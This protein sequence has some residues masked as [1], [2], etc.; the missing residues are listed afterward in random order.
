MEYDTRLFAADRLPSGHPPP[1]DESPDQQHARMAHD[2]L[3]AMGMPRV[4]LH[5]VGRF[6]IARNLVGLLVQDRQELVTSW[7]PGEPLA[8]PVLGA[9]AL[10]VLNEVDQLAHEDQ[11]RLLEWMNGTV[12]ESQ[13]I[14]TTSTSLL[15]KVN[16]GIFLEALFYRLNTVCLDVDDYS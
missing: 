7:T 10:L 8:L 9:R 13:V 1:S 4:N 6:G 5:V 3:R 14:T 12:G 2:E 16:T 11:L 15:P